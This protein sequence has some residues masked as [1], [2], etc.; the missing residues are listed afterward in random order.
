MPSI[1]IV[2][3]WWNHQELIPAYTRCINAAKL[4]KN[5]R[6]IVIDNGSVPRIQ[7]PAVHAP[8]L[9]LWQNVNYGFSKACNY[10][11][12]R[13]P[14]DAVLFLNN[15]IADGRHRWLDN[16]RDE[17][18]PGIMV[19]AELRF[20]QHATVDGKPIPYLDGWCIAAMREDL[21]DLGGWDESFEEPSYYGDNDLCLRARRAGMKLVQVP[22]ALRHISNVTSRQMDVSGVSGR[23][24]ERY[25]ARVR[26][27]AAM[28]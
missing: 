11:M 6:V 17:L 27:M 5:D 21:L 22:T 2:T 7:L 3:P 13:A 20:E 15:D 9:V 23:N 14:C 16:I 19:G 10:G 1:A 28:A 24:Y 12:R 8:L 26:E 4:G 18:A 25:A